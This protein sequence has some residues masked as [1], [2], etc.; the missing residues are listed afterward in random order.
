M[1]EER[2]QFLHLLS[3]DWGTYAPLVSSFLASDYAPLLVEAVQN[4]N[5]SALYASN[6]H[7]I[8]HILRTLCH[9]A[10]GC[11]LE[12]LSPEDSRLVLLACAYHDIGRVNDQEDTEHGLRSAQ[13]L[14]SLTGQTGQ[15]LA[16]L[17][18]AVDAHAR[19]DGQLTAVLQR[20]GVADT[21]RATALAWQLKDADGL[22]RVR[23]WD[24]DP[25]YLRL[26]HSPQRAPFAKELYLRYQAATG[27]VA[28]PD[29]VRQWKHLDADGN[30][31][32]E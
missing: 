22:D 4:L 8:G 26:P 1:M 31:L 30:P 13:R 27:G 17:Q 18:A 19:P 29:F 9:G 25:A 6:V 12:G 11:A 21:A 5:V 23:I 10:M 15:T 14:A 28:V 24:L 3:G 16:L 32:T 20:Y 7:G 2:E